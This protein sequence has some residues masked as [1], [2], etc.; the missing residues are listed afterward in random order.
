MSTAGMIFDFPPILSY[1]LT[2]ETLRI[3]Q[4]SILDHSSS[5]GQGESAHV[6]RHSKSGIH[7]FTLKRQDAEDT[8][9]NASQR[10]PPDKALER[11]D[12]QREFAKRQRAL[13]SKRPRAKALEIF[14]QGIFRPVDNPKILAAATFDCGLRHSAPPLGDKVHGLHDHS[15]A[16]AAS[17]LFPPRDP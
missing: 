7:W 6:R 2:K 11:L 5:Q 8:L 13:S 1:R 4:S 15:F 12:A 10:L 9:V 3:K 17:E 14:A 16:T